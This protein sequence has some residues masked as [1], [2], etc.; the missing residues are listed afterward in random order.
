[1]S[2]VGNFKKRKERKKEK[3]CLNHQTTW[4]N[5]RPEKTKAGEFRV[6]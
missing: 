4:K 6:P 1:M 2:K 5:R 3:K